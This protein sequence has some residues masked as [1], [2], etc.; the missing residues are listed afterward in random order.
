MSSLRNQKF[1]V[2]DYEDI[3]KFQF[4]ICGPLPTTCNGYLNS[5]V[6]WLINGVEKNIGIFTEQ[7]VF[8][9]GKIYMSMVGEKCIENGP[10]SLTTI[11]FVCDYL[12]SK[13]IDF[14]KVNKKYQSFMHNTIM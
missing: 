13:Y 6:C 9:N 5:A 10:P 3:A 1:E 2:N 7:V 8:D 11:Q 4:S 12:D 14:N